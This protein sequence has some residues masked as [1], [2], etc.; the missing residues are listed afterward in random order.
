MNDIP[1]MMLFSELL[2]LLEKSKPT[3]WITEVHNTDAYDPFGGM[4]IR[5][6]T[7]SGEII[8][9]MENPYSEI[10]ASENAKFMK[11]L[12][13]ALN[14][15]PKDS[16]TDWEK[17]FLRL[18]AGEINSWSKDPSTKVSSLLFRGKY[19]LMPSYNGF[20]PGIEDSLERLENREMKYKLVQHAEANAISNC[21]RLGIST[22]GASMAITHFPCS[23]CAGL[24]ISA[25][26]KKVIVQK[27]TEEF[28]SRWQESIDLSKSLFKEA[29]VEVRVIDLEND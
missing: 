22:D 23:N 26:I 18:A 14:P 3:G 15:Q 27:P 5:A 1:D 21:A 8:T 29:G 28:L 12:R 4:K 16:E 7:K 6:K 19:P 11:E 13:K 17:R 9:F 25:G 24:L 20:P 10:F 2:E